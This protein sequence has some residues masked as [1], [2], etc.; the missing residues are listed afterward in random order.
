MFVV[1]SLLS[2]VPFLF[3]LSSV[4][5]QRC[6][7]FHQCCLLCYTNM[8]SVSIFTEILNAFI[9]LVNLDRRINFLK[10]H[11]IGC[12]DIR[13]NWD[14]KEIQDRGERVLNIK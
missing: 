9:R 11:I 8:A 12:Y 7:N 4:S 10:S 14:K 13:D 5:L 2:K 3:H 1:A 6:N